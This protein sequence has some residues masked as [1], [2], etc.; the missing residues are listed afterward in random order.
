MKHY[1]PD[2]ELSNNAVIAAIAGNDRCGNA[3]SGESHGVT[4]DVVA[5]FKEARDLN[6]S[7][8]AIRP[9]P[10]LSFPAFTAISAITAF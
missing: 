5:S 10:P 4:E 2:M 8:P 3:E 6:S 1:L 9:L 7:V